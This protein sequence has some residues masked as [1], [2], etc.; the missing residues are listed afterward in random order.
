MAKRLSEEEVVTI[1]TLA[2]KG[3]NHCEI[4]RTLGITEGAVRY[5]LR[6]AAEEREDGRAKSRHAEQYAAV[7]DWWDE[8][9]DGDRPV[10]VK[11]LYEFLVTHYGYDG[12]YRS[13]LRYV[14]DRYPKP[15]VRTYRRVET[16]PGAQ[17]QTDWGVF[18]NVDVGDG[19][20]TLNAFVMVLSW[21]R[22]VAVVWA[23][24]QDQVSWLHCHNE[25]FRRL[26]G[27]PAVNRIDNVKTAMAQGAG[28]WGVIHPVYRSY[29]NVVGFHVDAC[30]PGEAAAKGKVEAKVRLVRLRVEPTWSSHESLEE[31]QYFSDERITSWS[32]KAT[33][34]ATGLSVHDSWE[35]ELEKLAPLPLMPEPFDVVVSRRVARDCTVKFEGRTYGVPFA[36]VGRQVEV[37]GCA[38]KVQVVAGNELLIEYPRGTDERILI[39]TSCYEGPST[40]RVK[41]PPPLGKMGQ[42][43]QEILDTPV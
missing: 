8:E 17:S 30:Q 1:R 3:Q 13:V 27:I 4:A 12:S 7:I 25:A 41:A 39:D 23:R 10:N 29:S 18:P 14:R 21:S 26:C 16:P 36:Y 19:P 24:R 28:A 31:L 34:P 38:G 22:M 5:R 6:K 2:A 32:R 9:H 43:L 11:E 20:E 33:C 35:R 37:R 40:D 42:R 15:R